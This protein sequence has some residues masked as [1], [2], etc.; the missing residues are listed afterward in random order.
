MKRSRYPPIL[1][2]FGHFDW[3]LT[4]DFDRFGHTILILSIYTEIFDIF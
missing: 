3:I 4:Y 1:N 2:I